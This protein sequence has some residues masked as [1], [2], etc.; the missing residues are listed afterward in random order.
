MFSKS[1]ET[2]EYLPMEEK[3]MGL[4]GSQ[5]LIQRQVAE[6]APAFWLERYS[7]GSPEAF[8]VSTQEVPHPGTPSPR[9]TRTVGRP[10]SGLYISYELLGKIVLMCV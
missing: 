6:R 10:I 3:G 1:L 8:L 5:C 4:R 7:P 9:Q 2:G